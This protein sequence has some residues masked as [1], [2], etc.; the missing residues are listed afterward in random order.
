MKKPDLITSTEVFFDYYFTQL[1]EQQKE[2][3]KLLKQL[4]GDKEVTENVE[5]SISETRRKRKLG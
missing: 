5:L 2:T 4:L 1:I 3:N